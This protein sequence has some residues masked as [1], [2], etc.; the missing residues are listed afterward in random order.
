MSALPA[1]DQGMSVSQNLARIREKL[2]P[3]VTLVA[4]TKAVGIDLLEEAFACGVTEFGE[5]RIQG[6]LTKQDGIPPNL[7]PHIHWHFIG[8]LQTNKARKAVGR[9]VLIH[10]LDSMRL[11][12]ELSAEA[13][14]LSVVQ[15]VL[16]QVKVVEDP[17]KTGFIPEEV[18]SNFIALRALT[19]IDIRGLMTMAPLT[20]DRDVWKRCFTGAKSL[21]DELQQFF[22][23]DLPHLSMGMSDDWE[24][25]VACGATMIRLGRAIFAKKEN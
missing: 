23:K 6:A 16:L 14:K 25:A 11:A 2:P 19:G 10:S 3:E 21:R 8:H 7:T 9:F 13:E 22:G 4:V 12:K 15:P 18:R 17:S 24:E 20:D 5:N 1:D